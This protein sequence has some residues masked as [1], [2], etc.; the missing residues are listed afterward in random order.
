MRKPRTSR[1]RYFTQSQITSILKR[2]NFTCIYC[3]K[4]AT[5]IDHIV[6]WELGGKTT[7][8]NGVSCCKSCNKLKENDSLG[9]YIAKGTAYINQLNQNP[10]K[11]VR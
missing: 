1:A 2:D 6:S 3:W 8:E 11:H 4:P 5:L 9:N 7:S 10:I